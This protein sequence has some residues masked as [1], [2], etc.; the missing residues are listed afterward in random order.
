MHHYGLLVMS[1]SLKTTSNSKWQ[2]QRAKAV[3]LMIHSCSHSSLHSSA[4]SSVHPFIPSPTYP[5]IHLFILII[6]SLV[7]LLVHSICTC[8][9]CIELQC[10][11]GVY[12]QVG[13]YHVAENRIN[14]T[15]YANI[16]WKGMWFLRNH[17]AYRFYPS[18]D[19][20][21]GIYLRPHV[22]WCTRK[23]MP[24][25]CSNFWRTRKD[26][27]KRTHRC[28]VA[29]PCRPPL[30]RMTSFERITVT[31]ASRL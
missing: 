6:H 31:C 26:S 11:G 18:V 1:N 24:S 5:S 10:T 9:C 17:H 7:R 14:W 3:F 28:P 16:F 23:D 8:C 22:L 29:T 13:L 27:I 20:L 21:L 15:G 4:H 25:C 2:G 30:S 12:E 19:P